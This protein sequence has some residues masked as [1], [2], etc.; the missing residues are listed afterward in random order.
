MKSTTIFGLLLCY[1][2]M[3]LSQVANAQSLQVYF[4]NLHS[5]TSYSDGSDTPEEAYAH[6]RDLAGLDFLAITEHN[7]LPGANWIAATH[8]LYSGTASTSLIST[9]ERF[10]QDGQFIA[11]YGQEFSSISSGN[12]AMSSRSGLRLFQVP[13]LKGQWDA[14]LNT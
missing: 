5:H 1:L 10:N 2:M 4:G 11:I 12:H 6:A 8:Q 14:L 7:H 13:C 3:S 9:A